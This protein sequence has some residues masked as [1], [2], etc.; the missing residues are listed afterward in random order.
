VSGPLLVQY[1]STKFA[2]L[3]VSEHEPYDAEETR[4]VEENF[5]DYVDW[6]GE[7]GIFVLE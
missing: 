1:R 7:V 2:D 5:E 3:W 6:L 4:D